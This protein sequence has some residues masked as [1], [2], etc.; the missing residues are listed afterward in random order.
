[1]KLLAQLA[2]QFG[3]W[4]PMS[5][6]EWHWEPLGSR[7]EALTLNIGMRSK[8]VNPSRALSRHLRQRDY[9]T[10]SANF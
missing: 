2:P 5:W 8:P 6:E 7:A 1:M 3:L 9:E 10:F 4:Q